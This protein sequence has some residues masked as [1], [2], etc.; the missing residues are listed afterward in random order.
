M[1]HVPITNFFNAYDL[2]INPYEEDKINSQE[3]VNYCEA[4]FRVALQEIM[5]HSDADQEWML[6]VLYRELVLSLTCIQSRF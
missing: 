3:V 6:K 1:S 5:K 2:Q 4:R